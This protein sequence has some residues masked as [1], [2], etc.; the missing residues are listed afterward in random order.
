[1]GL[2][3]K[4]F[5]LS[6]SSTESPTDRIFFFAA[7]KPKT[8]ATEEMVREQKT[9]RP[10]APKKKHS[11]VPHPAMNRIRDPGC[12]RKKLITISPLKKFRKK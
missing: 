11:P 2:S 3:L 6:S 7:F 10:E 1:M 9:I 8:R 4:L 12:M 5:G